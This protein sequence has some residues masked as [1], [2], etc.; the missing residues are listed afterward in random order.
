V[1]DDDG[2]A[3]ARFAAFCAALVRPLPLRV[4]PSFAAYAII[5]G[6]TFGV[7]LALLTLTHT[8]LGLPLP[9]SVTIGY[10]AAFWLSFVLNRTLNFRSHAPVGGQTLR[11]A[12]A[13]AVNYLAFILGVGAGLAA[14]GVE[15]HL[16]RLLAGAGEAIFMYSVMRWIVFTDAQQG[17]RPRAATRGQPR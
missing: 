5:N 6:F 15:Y 1:R 17:T 4:P 7:D 12:V 9:V 3:P 16:S 13:V 8:G 14:L 10:L 2:G 11:Y